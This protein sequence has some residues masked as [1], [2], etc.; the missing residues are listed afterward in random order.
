MPFG[1]RDGND[2][3]RT[4]C[5]NQNSRL[6]LIFVCLPLNRISMR[7]LV[8]IFLIGTFF[9]GTLG[10]KINQHYCCGNLVA[11]EILMGQQPKDCS[12]KVPVKPKKCCENKIQ[13]LDVD[14]S[15]PSRMECTTATNWFSTDGIP[16]SHF[17]SIKAPSFSWI[18]TLLQ[19]P[20]AP[21]DVGFAVAAFLRFGNLR[22]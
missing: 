16:F 1:N 11:W 19:I 4:K 10:L 22:I 18:Q 2:S 3:K 6:Q 17:I 14:D 8:S 7:F 20:K 5:N 13:I 9:L 12:G 21:P 15:K